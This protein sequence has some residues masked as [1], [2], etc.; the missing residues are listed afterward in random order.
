MAS[1]TLRRYRESGHLELVKAYC[2]KPQQKMSALPSLGVKLIARTL[3]L[4]E[5][6]VGSM[7][8]FAFLNKFPIIPVE[9]SEW[10]I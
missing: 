2:N 4:T 3:P 9:R 10:G 5:V 8:P 7:S 6:S 1:E